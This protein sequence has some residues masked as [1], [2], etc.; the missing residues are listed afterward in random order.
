MPNYTSEESC[1]ILL[2]E[3]ET[4]CRSK[5]SLHILLFVVKLCNSNR[6]GSSLCKAKFPGKMPL[7]E[8]PAAMEILEN[9]FKEFED[10]PNPQDGGSIFRFERGSN[11]YHIDCSVL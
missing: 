5:E 7:P 2:L 10:T 11:L 8:D 9:A 4:N 1:S 6:S 3:Y